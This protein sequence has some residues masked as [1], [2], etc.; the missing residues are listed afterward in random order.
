MLLIVVEMSHGGV[1]ESVAV[2]AEVPHQV[3]EDTRARGGL[4]RVELGRA[5]SSSGVV[6]VEARKRGGG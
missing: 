1:H 6:L 4:A 5:S 2:V 3:G